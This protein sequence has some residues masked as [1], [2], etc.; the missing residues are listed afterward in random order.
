MLYTIIP[1]FLVCVDDYFSVAIGPKTVPTL[2]ELLLEFAIVVDFSIEDGQDTFILV[3]HGLVAQGSVYDGEA[4]HAERHAIAYPDSLFV[5]ATM[6]NDP[7]H[8]VDHH[9]CIV[10]GVTCVN[11][12]RYSTHLLGSFRYDHSRRL[13]PGP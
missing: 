10:I 8:R 1:V 4:A 11:E 12:S 13:R 6:S 9:T 3:E 5:R 2:L 7:T